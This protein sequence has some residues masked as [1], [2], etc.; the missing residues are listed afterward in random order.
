[1][2]DLVSHL[3]PRI[4]NLICISLRFLSNWSCIKDLDEYRRFPYHEEKVNEWF[5][6]EFS[7]KDETEHK[8]VNIINV[9][10]EGR[11]KKSYMHAQP[12]NFPESLANDQF[13]LF[14]HVTNQHSAENII[15][16]GIRLE[17]GEEAQDFSDGIGYY[18]GNDFDEAVL[19][20]R[21][22]YREGEAV[23]I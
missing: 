23:L 8:A 5:V 10:G 18:V 14:V 11:V 9:D 12:A 15:E 20:A 13:E 19:W 21:N 3:Q 17:K 16:E 7:S 1:M 4:D 6:Q 2:L 22:K